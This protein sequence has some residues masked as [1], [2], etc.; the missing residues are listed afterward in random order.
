MNK[1]K[2]HNCQKCKRKFLN[3]PNLKIHTKYFHKNQKQIKTSTKAKKSLSDELLSKSEKSTPSECKLCSKFFRKDYLKV[4]TETVHE[5]QTK[6][7]C[8]ICNKCFGHSRTLKNHIIAIHEKLKPHK[9][10]FFANGFSRKDHLKRHI[11]SLHKNIKK[12][13]CQICNKGFSTNPYLKKHI[14]CVH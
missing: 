14:E 7:K 1:Q 8:H 11:D 3:L 5:K 4:H 6:F 13:V 12:H 9:C 10:S 2:L